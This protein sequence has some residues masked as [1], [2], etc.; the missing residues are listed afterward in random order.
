MTRL[1]C[2]IIAIQGNRNRYRTPSNGAG[3]IARLWHFHQGIRCLLN[4]S[5]TSYR[6]IWLSNLCQVAEV[7]NIRKTEVG[8]AQIK[9]LL[10][11]RPCLL[12][13]ALHFH[14][15]AVPISAASP[16]PFPFSALASWRSWCVKFSSDAYQRK[17]QLVGALCHCANVDVELIQ[18]GIGVAEEDARQFFYVRPFKMLRDGRA[19]RQPLALARF[20]LPH[21]HCMAH[22][23]FCGTAICPSDFLLPYALVITAFCA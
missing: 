19:V 4:S 11:F 18:I 3:H 12:N 23:H 7:D 22:R 16:S 2:R 6:S 1:T 5:Y 14:V 9:R 20:K 15:V 13:D 10:A 17:V 8:L 21:D